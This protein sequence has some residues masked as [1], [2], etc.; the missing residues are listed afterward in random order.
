LISTGA[1]LIGSPHLIDEESPTEN[2]NGVKKIPEWTMLEIIVAGLA[3]S[4][5]SISIIAMV[6]ESQVIAYFCGI[7][8]LIIPGYSVVQQKKITE[9][10][11]V[12]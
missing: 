3:V 5:A 10:K 11:G 12:C 9:C 2:H 8:G 1:N 6:T 7:M 4:T